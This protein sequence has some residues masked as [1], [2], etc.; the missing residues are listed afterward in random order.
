MKMIFKKQK[1]VTFV[2]KHTLMM[3]YGFE[4]IA[5]SQVITGVPHIK[6]AT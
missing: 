3:I 4:I 2:I 5:I 6:N 1:Y